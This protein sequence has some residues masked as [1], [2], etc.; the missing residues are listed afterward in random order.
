ME[1]AIFYFEKGIVCSKSAESIALGKK[2]PH[3][4]A[5]EMIGLAAEYLLKSIIEKND[6][7]VDASGVA[8]LGAILNEKNILPVDVVK[9]VKLLSLGCSSCS[10]GGDPKN[11]FEL[12]LLLTRLHTIKN[13][14]VSEFE[15]S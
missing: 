6:L 9:S 1:D 14:V 10:L 4:M 8:G 7:Y 15:K 13:W 12:P 11:Q 2:F 3:S 5:I